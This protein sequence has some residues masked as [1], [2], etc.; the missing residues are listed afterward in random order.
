[1]HLITIGIFFQDYF[2]KSLVSYD[3]IGNSLVHEIGHMIDVKQREYAEITNEV[4][5]E[6]A[7]QIIYKKN[8]NR[9]YYEDVYKHI[10]P[11]NIDNL[12]RYCYDKSICRGFFLNV[13]GYFFSCDIWWDI[14]SFYPGYWGN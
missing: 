11:D 1:M 9:K 3:G 4:L 10:A 12:S 7:V 8:L 5:E 6:Y 2:Y 13:G 14:E